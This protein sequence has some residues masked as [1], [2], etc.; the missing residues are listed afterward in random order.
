MA[1]PKIIHF[2][3]IGSSIPDWARDNIAQFKLL[4]PDY[5]IMIHGEEIMLPFFQDAYNGITNEHIYSRRSDILRICALL[6]HGGWYFDCD[7]L[8]FRPIN[9]IYREYPQTNDCFITHCD[10]LHGKPW[11]A[12]GIIGSTK[13]SAFLAQI[14]R[15]ILMKNFNR[16]P[17]CW[18]SY[19]T[20]I[21]TN[22][23]KQF[24]HLVTIGPKIDFYQHAPPETFELYKQIR[25]SGFNRKF[26]KQLVNNPMLFTLHIG[27][28]DKVTL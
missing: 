5:R 8:P 11:M 19:G 16:E 27:M 14:V 9:D 17:L 6:R 23:Q 12:N 15:S 18:G 13:D 1:L 10:Y 24:P 21:V 26:I 22:L 7:F 28:Q 25:E 3:W 20:E 4:N 2:I